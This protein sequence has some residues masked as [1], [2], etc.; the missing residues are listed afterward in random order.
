[1]QNLAG[2]WH[3]LAHNATGL[4][5]SMHAM[6]FDLA[7][8]ADAPRVWVDADTGLAMITMAACPK[9]GAQGYAADERHVLMLDGA[10]YNCREL[11]AQLRDDA[12]DRA[13]GDA[14]M[15]LAAIACWGLEG[16]LRRCNGAFALALW[17]RRTR[18]LTLARDR[19]GKRPLYYG[20]CGG[21]LVFASQ[22]KALQRAP[23][24]SA[25]IDRNA[26][27]AL[28]RYDYIPA[29]HS[30]FMGI[31]KLLPATLLSIDVATVRRR[32]DNALEDR[33]VCYWRAQE[34]ME[35][36]IS[37]RHNPSIDE[38]VDRLD[39]LL[40]ESVT[41]RLGEEGSAAAFL[42]GGTDSSLVVATLH[43]VTGRPVRT[44]SLGFDNFEHDETPWARA[45]ACRLGA[46]HVEHR[47]DGI[48]AA[49]LLP[50]L[51]SAYC[52]PFA[53]S[54]QIPTLIASRLVAR[55]NALAF[56]GDGGDELFFGHQAYQRAIR[57]ARVL[58]HVPTFARSLARRLASRRPERARLG[59]V[60][61]LLSELGAEGVSGHYLQRVS[62]W[63]DPAAVVRGA[64]EPMTVFT[65]PRRQLCAGEAVDQILLLDFQMD[66]PN[67]ILAKIDQAGRSA[68]LRTCSPFLD[69]AIVQFAWSLPPALKQI[70]GE[71][72][73][74]L[75][76][77][78]ERYLPAHLV[79]RPKSGFGA[80]VGDWLRGPMQEWAYDLL[81]E[82]RLR[83]E[84]FFDA[85]KVARLWRE[86]NAGQRK[87]H[88]HLWSILMFQAWYR[89]LGD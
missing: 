63:R 73:P 49:A 27:S 51:V 11:A 29:P 65:D 42:S 34:A 76:R 81:D 74:V 10:L 17:D 21:A 22:L 23:G 52:E 56:T 54:S 57:N 75:K 16:A 38:A 44:C 2:I 9:S 64:C 32:D 46:D 8:H 15:L 87:W 20:W 89:G 35:T 31:R 47:V 66:L 28:L 43:A 59:G 62:R 12:P 80:P 18:T 86:F 45:V 77:L 58:G 36:A 55:H 72:K 60:P 53:D 3:G 26:L 83:Q 14:P 25:R 33:S 30:I 82:S 37:R 71:G 61:A 68:G 67:G 41:C 24:F 13:V 1:M 79:Y 39:R 6:A 70:D 19:I 5:E 78:L 7:P 48:Q 40:R 85:E 84:G 50:S 88:T 69:P 4:I